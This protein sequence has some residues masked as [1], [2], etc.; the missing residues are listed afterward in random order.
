[1]G[2]RSAATSRTRHWHGVYTER[3]EQGVSWFAEEPAVS[4]K[5]LDVAGIRTDR[6]VIDV[7]AGASRLVDE[8]LLR[9]HRDLTAL[10]VSDHGLAIARARLGAAADDVHWLV[11]DLLDWRPHRRFG[12][13]H[14]RAVFHFLADPDDRARY[15]AVLDDTL[16]ADG[17]LVIATFAQDGPRACS[18]L[19]TVGYSA[20]ELLHALGGPGRWIELVRRREH[21][22]TPSGV[23]QAFSWTA[24]RR[25]PA[26]AGVDDR[27]GGPERGLGQPAGAVT[28]E[29]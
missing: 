22:V 17:V 2:Q 12:A 24:L 9:G 13:W 15:R 20:D 3:G 7:G 11:A 16:D 1:M 10:D 14:D 19:P 28:I 18:G 27:A 5:L 26:A 4:L 23:D 29:R 21:H 8:L 25:R 6:S